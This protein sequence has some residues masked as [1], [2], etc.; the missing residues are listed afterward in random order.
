MNKSFFEKII[1]GGG[2]FFD[3]GKWLFAVLVVL[4]LVNT[5]L[6]GVFVVDG[7]SMQPNFM[8]K[9]IVLWE[10]S[11]LAYKET[12]PTRGEVVLVKYPGDPLHKQY[13]KRV[14]GLPDET[15]SILN[16]Q[17]Y[18]NDVLLEESYIPLDVS[19]LP[20]GSWAIDDNNFFV[21]G[22]NRENSN[23]SRFFGPVEKRFILGRAISVIFPRLLFVK[24][25]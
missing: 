14:I 6:I 23:D 10:K 4:A 12:A 5:F 25:M 2:L 24:D 1:Y 16:G 13:V 3:L 9:E 19:T 17:V 15:I 18:I 21:M 22:D 8:N 11:S 20:N 7:E